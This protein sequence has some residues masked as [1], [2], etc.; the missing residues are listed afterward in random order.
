MDETVEINWKSRRR[1]G[2]ASSATTNRRA[3]SRAAR[4]DPAATSRAGL[5]VTHAKDLALRFA[6]AIGASRAPRGDDD[7][8]GGGSRRP[9]RGL[10]APA[11]ASFFGR[12]YHTFRVTKVLESGAE[13]MWEDGESTTLDQHDYERALD[14]GD[15]NMQAPRPSAAGAFVAAAP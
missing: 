13:I 10:S 1:L 12:G 4:K 2:G 5:L 14:A 15:H 7:F 3:F 11:C 6:A 8:R 9:G